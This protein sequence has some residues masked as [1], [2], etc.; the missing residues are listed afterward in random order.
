MNPSA[1]PLPR[2]SMLGLGLAAGAGVLTG[3]S[4]TSVGTGEGPGSSSAGTA[5]RSPGSS[6]V[7]LVVW[8]DPVRAAALT[9]VGRQ[10]GRDHAG[11]TIKVVEKSLADIAA[12]LGPAV[13]DGKGPDLAVVG[14]A[15]L[16]TL[17]AAGA[18]A[19]MELGDA[20]GR[21]TPQTVAAFTADGQ[22]YGLP[23][24]ASTVGLIRNNALSHAAPATWDEVL[25]AGSAAKKTYPVM[26]GVGPDGDAHRLFGLQSS[27]G[28]TAFALTD[29]GT[30]GDE[31]TLGD[32]AGQ[33]FAGWL[34]AQGAKGTKALDTR[35]GADRAKAQFL[36]AQAP[37]WLTG[38]DDAAELV[39]TKLDVAVLPLPS[40]GGDPARPFL[41]VEGFVLSARSKRALLATDFCVNYLSSVELQLAASAGR[42]PALTAAAEDSAITD[43]KVLAGFVEVSRGGVP[44]PALAAMRSVWPLWSGA[45]AQVIGGADPD[46]TWSALAGAV[47]TALARAG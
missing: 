31:V 3:C 2:R 10:F 25:S 23:C 24:T 28:N 30:L 32:R 19:P 42:L 12:Q 35:I 14:H 21:F 41:D 11:A 15:S 7:R 22:V 46:G 4:A 44:S 37:F 34:A 26:V 9:A 43:D 6:A 40:A 39:R 17:R 20:R 18:V 33:A 38:P 16:G 47:D 36:D 5:A 1:R 45:E 13:A 27:F 8:A 29:D